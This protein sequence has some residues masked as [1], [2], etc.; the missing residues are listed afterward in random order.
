M[1]INTYA[2]E[3]VESVLE[4]KNT[5]SK[6]K[7]NQ[8]F[9]FEV[10]NLWIKKQIEKPLSSIL[11]LLMKNKVILINT[12]NDIE[13]QI[14]NTKKVDLKSVLELSLQRVEMQ[15]RDINSFIPQLEASIKKLQS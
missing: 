10:Y 8:M 4:L 1:S 3:A 11:D 12:R 6:S 2:N 14:E 7:Y 5:I 9:S 15:L 13:T